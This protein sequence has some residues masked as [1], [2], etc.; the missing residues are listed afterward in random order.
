MNVEEFPNG[1]LTYRIIGLAMHVHR[2]LGP[3]LLESI[4]EECLR[5]EL[6]KAN[7]PYQHR[8]PLPVR[9]GNVQ[10]QGLFIADII[11]VVI[12]SLNAEA[13]K[14]VIESWTPEHGL[15]KVERS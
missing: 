12:T 8:V 13:T 15:R 2:Q 10:L 1:K 6:T 5:Y 3:G 11:E 4:Y 14:L 7:I 9:Y